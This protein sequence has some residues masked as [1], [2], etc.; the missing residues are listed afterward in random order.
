MSTP[1]TQA[2]VE[3][4]RVDDSKVRPRPTFCWS[5]APRDWY[6]SGGWIH[7]QCPNNNGRS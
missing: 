1:E 2:V 4:W 5:Y 7:R 3:V 6:S